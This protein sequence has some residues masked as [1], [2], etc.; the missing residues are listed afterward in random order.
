MINIRIH[1]IL[2]KWC[3]CKRLTIIIM[4]LLFLI[5]TTVGGLLL[6]QRVW[7]DYDTNY[8]QRFNS[9]KTDI[10][11]AI[12]ESNTNSKNKLNDI[13]LIQTDLTRRIKTYC[14]ITPLIKW[15]KF[16]EQ[17]SD[18][19]N[20]CTQKKERLVQLLVD[21]GNMTTYL[22]SEQ[23]LAAIISDANNKTGQNNQPD[24]WKNIEAFWRKAVTDTSKLAAIDQFKVVKTL[25]INNLTK[26]A[27]AWQQLSSANDAKNRQQFTDARSSLGQTYTLLPEI[28]T[29][30]KTQVEKIISDLNRDYQK[31]Q[32]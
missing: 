31:I 10:N 15:Q 20:D 27:N 11:Q 14:E 32:I 29:S 30:S 3:T 23:Q 12:S 4:A 21:I 2:S 9:A 1:R 18:K 16:I 28:A 5:I 24:K 19:I 13:A 17:Y 26:I 25:A 22:K 7:S 8:N 6:S